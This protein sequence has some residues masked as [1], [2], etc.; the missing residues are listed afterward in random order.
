MKP[1]QTN[2]QVLTWLSMHP[3]DKSTSKSK[4]MLYIAFTII[5]VILTLVTVISSATSFAIYITSDIEASLYAVFQFAAN[6]AVFNLIAVGMVYRHRVASIFRNLAKFYAT[7]KCRWH[8]NPIDLYRMWLK[9]W[10]KKNHFIQIK[11]RFRCSIW[12]KQTTR[13]NI[14]GIYSW[15]IFWFCTSWITY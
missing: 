5:N 11:V 9:F 4:R 12:W 10:R 6:I 13:A 3:V 7:S 1:L 8:E 2:Q 15:D 14:C